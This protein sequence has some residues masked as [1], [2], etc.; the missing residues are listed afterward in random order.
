METNFRIVALDDAEYKDLF[1]LSEEALGNK[2]AVRKIVDKFPGYPCRVSLQD[3]EIGDEVLLISHTHHPG[4]SPYRASGPVFIR[5]GAR[6][7][8]REINEIHKMLE[9]RLLSLRAYTQEGMMIAAQTIKGKELRKEIHTIFQDL[10]SAYI[11]IH[12]AAPGCYNCQV[13]RA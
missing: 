13:N 1:D 4:S 9:H 6:Q 3:A 8:R 2:D 5:K 12:N 7:A 10:A 11:H